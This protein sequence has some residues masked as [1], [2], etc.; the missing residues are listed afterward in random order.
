MDNV[1]NN[2]VPNTPF[3]AAVLQTN[4]TPAVRKTSLS[5]MNTGNAKCSTSKKPKIAN[6][7]EIHAKQFN[8]AKSITDIVSR[9]S[10]IGANMS[11]ALENEKSKSITNTT[12]ITTNKPVVVTVTKPNAIK[13]RSDLFGKNTFGS[14]SIEQKTAATVANTKLLPS[15]S[16]VANKQPVKVKALGNKDLTTPSFKA[17]PMPNFKAVHSK[18]PTPSSASC[19]SESRDKENR[20]NISSLVEENP[21]LKQSNIV[22]GIKSFAINKRASFMPTKSASMMLDKGK[23]CRQ[24]AFMDNSK[25]SRSNVVNAR[26]TSTSNVIV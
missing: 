18:L 10:T 12:N 19:I 21:I 20:L 11:I 15:A 24:S 23:S 13:A 4:S 16:I 26:R 7:A 1:F 22:S 2:S 14:G 6:F 3:V 8:N 9:D 17:R 25:V 5:N